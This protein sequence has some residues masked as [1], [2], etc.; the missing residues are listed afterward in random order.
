MQTSKK[1]LDRLKCSWCGASA[2]ESGCPPREEKSVRARL[3]ALE[4]RVEE[5]GPSILRAIE[6]R[7]RDRRRNP[8]TRS[9]TERSA[10]SST[11]QP[12]PLPREQEGGEWK[13]VEKEGRKGRKKQ[14]KKEKAATKAIAREDAAAAPPARGEQSQIRT[15]GTRKVSAAPSTGTS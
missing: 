1:Q 9:R 14:K 10:A 11:I 13:V 6:E 2:S 15:K 4:R 12:S 8:E 7:C 3:A 5:I